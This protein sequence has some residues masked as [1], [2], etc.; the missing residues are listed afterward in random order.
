MKALPLRHDPIAANPRAP[1]TGNGGAD[2]GPSSAFGHLLA[3]IN[4]GSEAKTP[5]KSSAKIP[6]VAPSTTK[7]PAGP[8]ASSASD[9]ETPAPSDVASL[10]ERLMGHDASGPVETSPSSAPNSGGAEQTVTIAVAPDA[11]I[12]GIAIPGLLAALSSLSTRATGAE[13]S[14]AKVSSTVADPTDNAARA[15]N[16]DGADGTTQPLVAAATGALSASLDGPTTKVSALAVSS[17]VAPALITPMSRVLAT[18]GEAGSARAPQK[19]TVPVPLETDADDASDGGTATAAPAV[20]VTSEDT[21]PVQQPSVIAG[22]GGSDMAAMFPATQTPASPI[23]A[24]VDAVNNMVAQVPDD[25]ASGSSGI[26]LARTMTLQI[27]PGTSGTVSIRMRLIGRGLDL[28][29]SVSDPRTLGLINQE[30]DT[31]S[32]ALHDQSYTLDTLV[33]QGG[34]ASPAASGA[35]HET[36]QQPAGGAGSQSSAD[37]GG[38]SASGGNGSAHGGGTTPPRPQPDRETRVASPALGGV[39]V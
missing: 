26:A 21:G 22:L 17:Q 24:V 6:A 8:A 18:A 19:S 15:M 7:S 39:F 31:L 29:L 4:A 14:V 2:T 25:S 38:R 13:A 36:M 10:V 11:S 1:Q 9:A 30:R 5:A 32:A 12:L 23:N 34:D 35:D 27:S 28:K 3:D 37:A 20:S 16:L 33:I